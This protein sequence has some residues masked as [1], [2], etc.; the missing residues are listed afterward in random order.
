MQAYNKIFNPYTN[1]FIKTNSNV[2]RYLI[3]NMVGGAGPVSIAQL[4]EL[5]RH[6]VDFAT[7]DKILDSSVYEDMRILNDNLKKLM[8]DFT[9]VARTFY[10]H[11][12]YANSELDIIAR[13]QISNEA[14]IK[15]HINRLRD[16][17]I[18]ETM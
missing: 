16:L 13:R 1:S 4:D 9:E 11:R 3:N 18:H 2:G 12:D 5:E 6:F 7:L 15:D 8:S 14:I 10:E 17:E